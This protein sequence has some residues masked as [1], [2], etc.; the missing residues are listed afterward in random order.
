MKNGK[1]FD[2]RRYNYLLGILLTVFCSCSFCLAQQQSS[3]ISKPVTNVWY[4]SGVFWVWPMMHTDRQSD[5]VVF[6]PVAKTQKNLLVKIDNGDF[7]V[8]TSNLQLPAKNYDSYGAFVGNDGRRRLLYFHHETAPK[9]CYLHLDVIDPDVEKNTLVADASILSFEYEITYDIEI[10]MSPKKEI[11]A[12]VV[13]HKDYADNISK[14]H[15]AVFDQNGNMMW[16]KDVQP[17]LE[18]P[19]IRTSNYCLDDKGMLYMPILGIEKDKEGKTITKQ[20]LYLLKIGENDLQV[21]PVD[22]PFGVTSH[23]MAQ[24]SENGKVWIFGFY[25]E[26]LNELA[27]E[28][29]AFLTLFDPVSQEFTPVSYQTF[30][31][32][33][34]AK[35]PKTDLTAPHPTRPWYHIRG[36]NLFELPNG[37]VVVCGEHVSRTV[38]HSMDYGYYT[39]RTGDILVAKFHPDHS[40]TA[41]IV[42]KNQTGVSIIRPKD[43]R[44]SY[45]SYSAFVRQNDLYLVYNDAA[46]NVPFPGKGEGL[47]ISPWGANNK[48]VSVCTKIA[49]NGDVSQQAFVQFQDSK[50]MF[51]DFLFADD[52]DFYVSLI[53]KKGISFAKYPLPQ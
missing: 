14:I 47:S 29:G 31:A 53:Q 37:D 19:F 16:E 48:C 6:Q 33:Y 46:A 15:A 11:F 30:D 3:V 18:E 43:W 50:Q 23:V 25:Q 32:D 12:L 1:I 39:C 10:V 52:H 21:N 4:Q 38:T 17:E 27:T 26:G 49:D 35:Y 8:T 40:F 20:H 42:P 13:Y 28:T 34:F 24:L 2:M 45:V 41:Q 44:Q 5:V 22:E 7:S 36:N 51:R 9:T